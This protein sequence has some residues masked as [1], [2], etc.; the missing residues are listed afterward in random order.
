MAAPPRCAWLLLLCASLSSALDN[1]LGKTPG[2]GWNSDYCTNCSKDANGFQN[3]KFIAHIA[4]AMVEMGF[5]ELG[6]KYVN[7]DAS[8]DTSSRDKDGN[9]V[10]DPIL[11]PSGMEKTIEYVHSKGLGFGL[12]GDKGTKD[13]ARNPGQLGHE[14]QDADFLAK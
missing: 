10:P 13:C 14:K 5:K 8:W 3:E 6:Y 2:M 12:Y 11:W 4:D 1:G 7:M 9:L